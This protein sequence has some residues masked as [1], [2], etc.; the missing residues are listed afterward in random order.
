MPRASRSSPRPPVSDQF[1]KKQP[2]SLKP[3]TS[4]KQKE[5]SIETQRKAMNSTPY[6][7]KTNTSQWPSMTKKLKNI[8]ADS[9]LNKELKGIP[10][11]MSSGRMIS[12][13]PFE[14][15]KIKK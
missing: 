9:Y 7:H 5:K 3:K 6:T 10:T 14:L 8:E 15:D 13:N 2:K 4:P 11:E 1:S 12:K